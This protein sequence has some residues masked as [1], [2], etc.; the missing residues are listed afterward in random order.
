LIQKEISDRDYFLI[1]AS[2]M[3]RDNDK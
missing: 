3:R 2:N 1:V